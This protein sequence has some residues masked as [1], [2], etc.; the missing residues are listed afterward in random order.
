MVLAL[1]AGGA[2]GQVGAGGAE[3]GDVWALLALAVQTGDVLGG[4]HR[5]V[6]GDLSGGEGGG[7]VVGA[8][9]VFV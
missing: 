4:V 7:G 8:V 5:E 6:A 2:V 9:A 3:G 1:V